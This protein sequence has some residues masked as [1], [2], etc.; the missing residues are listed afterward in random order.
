M[1]ASPVEIHVTQ[2]K[3][4]GFLWEVIDRGGA[5]RLPSCESGLALTEEDAKAEAEAIAMELHDEQR[6]SSAISARA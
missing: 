1:I 2:L 5:D 6:S 3:R 4:G